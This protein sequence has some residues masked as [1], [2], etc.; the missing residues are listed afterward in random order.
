[1][2]HEKTALLY[3]ET[4]LREIGLVCSNQ[5]GMKD[6]S[7]L[8][9]GGGSPALLAPHLRVVI[10][11][12]RKYFNIHDGIGV[13]LHP[14]DVTEETLIT[15]KA[16]GVTRISIGVQSFGSESLTVL[17]RGKFDE[18]VLFQT[19]RSVSFETVS[20]DFIF[21]MPGQTFDMV[22]KDIDTAF[23]NGANHIALYPFIDFAFTQ[24]KVPKM[25][26][27]SKRK[28]LDGITDY[29]TQMGFVR[30]SIWTFAKPDTKPYSSMTRDNFLG[31]G[32]SATTLLDQQ[33][34]INTFSVDGYIQRISS[35]NLPTSL[36]LS[37]TRGQRMVYYLFW[38]FYTTK[39]NHA[40]FKDFFGV[41]VTKSYV[42]E[43]WLAELLG[44][45]ERNGE[46]HVM[47]KKGAFYY[48]Y[49]EQYYTLSY[50]DKMWGLMGTEAFPEK[51]TL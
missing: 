5:N 27:A 10:A 42:F 16:A 24:S 37:F 6:V 15:L 7:S 35:G 22:K 18:K 33:F 41:T 8:Y 3:L 30:D 45:I 48:H 44:F 51:M 14:S 43:L 4:L 17:G 49:F 47:T 46:T 34:K 38:R 20:M 12:L 31:F 29:C 9:F 13:E 19:L 11:A 40:D 36:T 28:L 21:A 39:L 26:S 23:E 50:I 25:S 2:Y 32:C 1:L